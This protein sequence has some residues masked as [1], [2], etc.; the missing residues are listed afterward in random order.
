MLYFLLGALT[1]SVAFMIA[2]PL[3]YGMGLKRGILKKFN[4]IV[5]RPDGTKDLSF[6]VDADQAWKEYQRRLMEGN[7]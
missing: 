7:Y 4:V 1:A 2:M 6:T 3:I 5:I